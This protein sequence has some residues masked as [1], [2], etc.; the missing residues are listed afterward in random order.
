M[1]KEKWNKE[2]F[3]GLSDFEL[4]ILQHQSKRFPQDKEFRVAVLKE[5]SRRDKENNP[6]KKPK[7]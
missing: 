7:P 4:A 5:L 2:T 1:K 3:I 6:P